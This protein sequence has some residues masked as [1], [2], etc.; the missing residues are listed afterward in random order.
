MLRAMVRAA[1]GAAGLER[2]RAGAARDVSGP[3]NPIRPWQTDAAFLALL[4]E[5]EGRTLVDPVRLFVLWQLARR[6]CR[7]EGDWAEV[8]VYRGGTARLLGRVAASRRQ[9][10]L[11][12][13]FAGMPEADAARDHHVA[14]DFADT[15]L[16]AV[17]D[18]LRDLA[19]M[20]LHPGL[21]PETGAAVAGRRFSLV[22]VDA[23][24]HRSVAACCAFFR[25][26]LVPGG[27]LVFDDYGFLSCPGAKQAVDEHCA[28]RDE[29]PIY[30]PTG[31]A[32]V[33][34]G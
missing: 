6:A 27:V 29:V 5:V 4:A 17:R 13:T 10:H 3:A 21:F 32:L 15:S 24:L 20:H 16:A 7:L 30:L 34:A 31:Q 12:D 22:H 19:G 28:V 2:R 14:G 23:D 9:V 8:G 1:L 25:P 18:Y 11:F 33:I 26:R